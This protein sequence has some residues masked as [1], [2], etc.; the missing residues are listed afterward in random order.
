MNEISFGT[1]TLKIIIGFISL[2]LVTKIV[3]KMQIKQFTPFYF[4]SALVLGEILGNTFYDDNIKIYHFVY[5]LALWS[6]LLIILAYVTLTFNFSR[7]FLEGAPSI[8]IRNGIIVKNELKKNKMDINELQGLLRKSNVFSVREVEYAI[9]ED[10]GSLS[11]LKKSNYASPTKQDLNISPS[12]VNLSITL[13][14]D[15]KIIWDNLKE[16][17]FDQKWLEQQLFN[18]GIKNVKDLFY[19]EWKD[20]EGFYFNLQN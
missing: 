14:I 12:P 6:G 16:R 13:V 2:F 9:L 1:L 15:G 3:G 17:G 5:S 18:H 19:A 8:L 4:V 7:G 10:D 20:G 11:V